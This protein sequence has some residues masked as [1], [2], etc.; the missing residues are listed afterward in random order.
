MEKKYPYISAQKK[1]EEFFKQLQNTKVLD[2]IDNDYLRRMDLGSSASKV[3]N[4]LKYIDFIDNKHKTTET[5]KNY[6]MSSD[7]PAT[8]GKILEKNYSEIF[9]QYPNAYSIDDNTLLTF[10]K[11]DIANLNNKTQ[12][13]VVKTFK[14]LCKFASF[15]DLGNNDGENTIN[16]DNDAENSN[17]NP[18]PPIKNDIKLNDLPVTININIQIT[19]PETSNYDIYENIFKAL[20]KNLMEG[21][22]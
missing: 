21:K 20:K 22:D 8:L 4:I 10:I 3:I 15:N 18:P 13:L 5:Y 17:K 14:I 12:G 6:I 19:L 2:K 11:P 16:K 9:N 7:K 1:F